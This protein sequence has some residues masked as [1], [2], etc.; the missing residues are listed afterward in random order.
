VLL[1]VD[2]D[3]KAW[4]FGV[5]WAYCHMCQVNCCS[6]FWLH[7]CLC[8][9]FFISGS[10]CRRNRSRSVSDCEGWTVETLVML[11]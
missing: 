7:H 8:S 3:E 2:E 6:R 4:T 9:S 1:L 11:H 5:K 10:V